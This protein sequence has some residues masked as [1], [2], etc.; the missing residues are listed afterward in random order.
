MRKVKVITE[1]TADLPKEMA[2]SHNIE[3]IPLH[4]LLGGDRADDGSL[5]SEEMFEF[6]EKTDT[7]PSTVLVTQDEFE[8]VFEKWLR[9]DYDIL[10]IGMSNSISEITVQNAVAASVAVTKAAN[11]ERER[12]S[13]VDS[14]SYSCGIGLLSLEAAELAGKGASLKEV[15]EYVLALRP[16]VHASFVFDKVKYYYMLGM[17]SKFV[18]LVGNAVE[19]KPVLDMKSGTL[20]GIA[21]LTGKD[22]V[23]KYCERVMKDSERIDP[24]RIFIAH[25]LNPAAAEEV[26]QKLAGEYGF[27]N[28]IITNVSPSNARNNGPGMLGIS[29]LYK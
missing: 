15:T 9:E 2:S 7:M 18:T 28:V 16:K 10:F 6:I 1:S 11:I 27:E 26:K 13:V 17:V 20:V 8:R 24:K 21:N 14:L 4:I 12:I 25:C 3:I 19:V 5:K 22:Y 23:N 29:F